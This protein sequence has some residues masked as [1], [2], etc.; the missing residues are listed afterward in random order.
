MM[1]TRR[2]YEKIAALC[3]DQGDSTDARAFSKA[4]GDMFARD[5][6]RFDRERFDRAAERKA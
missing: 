4:L 6:S 5:N 2:H 3:R 1:F